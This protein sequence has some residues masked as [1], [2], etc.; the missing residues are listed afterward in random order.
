MENK[1]GNYDWLVRF[2]NLFFYD[3]RET[4]GL[5]DA[6][7]A[8]RKAHNGAVLGVSAICLIGLTYSGIVWV[9]GKFFL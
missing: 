3:I 6:E 8:N 1:N 2:L 5:S 4:K 7:I 9:L